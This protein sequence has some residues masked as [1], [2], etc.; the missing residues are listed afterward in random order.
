MTQ[1]KTCFKCGS[2]KTAQKR[3]LYKITVKI[4]LDSLNECDIITFIQ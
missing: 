3:L 2:V 4:M 1:E